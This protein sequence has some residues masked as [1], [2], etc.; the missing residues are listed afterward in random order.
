MVKN[1]F[2]LFLTLISFDVLAEKDFLTTVNKH[3]WYVY[4]DSI[5]IKNFDAEA[6][7]ETSRGQKV[8]RVMVS[9]RIADCLGF[10]KQ[11]MLSLKYD[12]GEILSSYF[13]LASSKTHTLGDNMAA[14]ICYHVNVALIKMIDEQNK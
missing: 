10:S 6:L 12:D 9:V 14:F 3:N 5:V 13:T 8:L 2:L 1:F 4:D 11:G 7:F